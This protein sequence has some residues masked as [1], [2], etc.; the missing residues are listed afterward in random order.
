MQ[1]PKKILKRFH[2]AKFSFDQEHSNNAVDIK[3]LLTMHAG[4][5]IIEENE[6]GHDYREDFN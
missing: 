6:T 3:K 1:K 4:N 5:E 2:S